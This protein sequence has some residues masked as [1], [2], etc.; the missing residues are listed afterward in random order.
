MYKKLILYIFQILFVIPAKAG[1]QPAII[2]TG[3]PIEAL[4]DDNRKGF[5]LIEALLSIVV[6]SALVAAVAH[7]MIK[8]MDSY[9]I[10]AD[11]REALQEARL[12]VNMMSDE[13]QTI[14]NPAT[15]ISAISATSITFTP[16]A[17]GSVTY[18][19][20][21]TEL[22]RDS[23]TLAQNVTA[24]SGFIYYTAGGGITSTPSLIYRIHIRV[25]ISSTALHGN[26]QINS[27]VYLRNRYYNAF[28]QI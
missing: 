26:V 22:R 5:T 25:E 1:I 8:G 17:G 2:K 6:I 14:A 23:K 24:S 13:L 15:D 19:I 18:S 10:I 7:T 12:A 20:V 16:A 3:S 9:S 4:G 11:R 21:G 28:T 27:N